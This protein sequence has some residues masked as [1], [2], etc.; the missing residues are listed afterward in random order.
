MKREYPEHPMVGVGAFI[1]KNDS[2]LLVKREHEPGKG[3]WSL[4]GGLVN[5]GEK[6]RDAIK[7][8][9]EEEVGLKVDVVNI[10]DVFD[11]VEYDGKCR[12]HFHYV[13]IGFMVKPV[14]GKVRGSKEASQVK[15]FKA[16]E[17]KDLEMTVTTRKLLKEVN[18]LKD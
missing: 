10:V 15:W 17:L 2:V 7:R 18:F 16:E 11:S 6:I 3:K 8:E 9:V 14:G 13:I 1:K 4:P 5:L 12:V